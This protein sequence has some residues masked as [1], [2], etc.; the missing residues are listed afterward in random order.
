MMVANEGDGNDAI[1][2][3]VIIYGFESSIRVDGDSDSNQASDDARP[4]RFVSSQHCSYE[5]IDCELSEDRELLIA[6]IS[7]HS[8]NLSAQLLIGC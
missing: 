5:A 3:G 6:M 7:V 2:A 1:S 4:V 8:S